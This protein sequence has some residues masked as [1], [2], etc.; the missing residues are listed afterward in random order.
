MKSY[1][2]LEQSKILAEILPLESA[3]MHYV[4]IDTDENKYS[5]GLEKYIGIL[6]H[7]PCWSLAA[8]LSVLP[9]HLI[10][11]NHRYAFGMYKGLNREG[12]TYML[13]YNVFNTH[14]CLYETGYYNNAIDACYEMICWLKENKKI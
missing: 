14:I 12:E 8:L 10:V 5:A 2:D 1:T 11:N 4:L 13:S 3:D 7:Y 9:F 6:P